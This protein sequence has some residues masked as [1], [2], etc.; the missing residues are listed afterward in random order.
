MT[1]NTGDRLGPY[2]IVALIGEGGMGQVYRARDTRLNSEV[3]VK[4]S[5]AEFSERFSRE[6]SLVASLN[7]PNICT[8]HDVGPNFL[9]ME[10]VEGPSLIDRMAQGPIPLGEAVA[11]ALQIAEAL[12]AAHDKGIIHRDLKPANIKFTADGAVKVLDFGLA[13]ALDG[14]V[15]HASPSNSP[16][17]APTRVAVTQAGYILGTASYMAPEQARGNSAD[18]RADIWSFGVVLWEMVTGRR[19]FA[20]ETVGDTLALVLTQTPDIEAAPPAIRPLLKRCLEKDRKKRLQAIGEARIM[21]ETPLQFTQPE[22]SKPTASS[23]LPW[24][25]VAGLALICVAALG[26]LWLK[27]RRVA[28]PVISFDVDL[29]VELPSTY[30]AGSGIIISPDGRRIVFMDA[31]RRLWTRRL[32]QN[33]AVMLNG[34]DDAQGPFFSPDSRWVGFFAGGKL[35]KIMVEGGSPVNICDV[36]PGFA[37][38][39]SWSE[40]GTIV[41]ALDNVG[42]LSRVSSSGGQPVPVTTLDAARKEQTHRFPYFLPGGKTFLFTSSSQVANFDGATIELQSVDGK[43]RRTLVQGGTF[44]RYL[45][46]GHLIYTNKQTLLAAPFDASSLQLK[47]AS[48]PVLEGVHY[49]PNIGYAQV[50]ISPAGMA[51]YRKVSH[52]DNRS[53]K[54][55]DSSG[56]TAPLLATPGRYISIRFSPEGKRLALASEGSIWVYDLARETMT[57]L[58]FDVSSDSPIWTPDGKYITFRQEGIWYVR[59]DGGS[60]P[61]PLLQVPGARPMTVSPDGKTLAYF[62]QGDFWTIPLSQEADRLRAGK[63]QPLVDAPGG[64][65]I[66]SPDGK[67][68]AYSSFES[69]RTEVYVRAANGVGSKWQVSSTGGTAPRWSNSS[70]ELFWRGQDM[71]LTVASYNVR[72]DTFQADKPRIWSDHRLPDTG[73]NISNF[74]LHPDG[75]RFAIVQLPEEGKAVTT[76]TFLLNFAD[77][78]RRKF[79][80]PVSQ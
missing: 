40:D 48:V 71:R 16:T 3:A 57:R 6:A 49:T 51:V 42:P 43:T 22:Q 19:M 17:L 56:H 59:A 75:K 80:S 21:L 67:W 62:D 65:G 24:V 11:I 68:L 36:V 78:M 44:A 69:G 15:S 35:K 50:D 13:K 41:L 26:L 74:D 53:I 23:R 12:E 28:Q 18:R 30:M 60:K 79:E 52:L 47:G 61:E 20:G 39:A 58:N 33:S 10:L 37:R 45:S 34:T 46:S 73:G 55:L 66:Y 5:A 38:G 77:E 27:A 9:V 14:D 2:E 64:G 8:L 25:L 54:W 32:D 29:G 70:R 7:H 31:A 63:P 1:I 72:G 76:V 4:V